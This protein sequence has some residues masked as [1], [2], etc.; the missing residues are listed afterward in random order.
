MLYLTEQGSRLSR[1]G[2]CLVVSRQGEVMA[3]LPAG[4]V[5]QVVVFGNVSITTP[6]LTYLLRNGVD[7]VF[8]SQEGHYFGRLI[9]SSSR[10]GLLRQAQYQA[11]ADADLR[12]RV[13]RSIVCGKLDNYARYLQHLHGGRADLAVLAEMRERAAAAPDISS[14]RGLEGQATAAYFAALRSLVPRHLA[15]PRRTKRP[16]KDPVNSMLSLGYTLLAYVSW[17]AVEQ[18]GLDVYS[19]FLH[20]TVYSRPSLA[21]DLIEEVRTLVDDLVLVAAR[22]GGYG[23]PDFQVR[24]GGVFLG[25]EARKRY[26]RA[27]QEQVLCRPIPHPS[28][29]SPVTVRRALELQARQVAEIVLGRRQ[30]YGP[31]V[32]WRVDGR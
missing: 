13:A 7:C 14:L 2:H 27:F 19:G 23:W 16:P 17:S 8:L 9:S 24:N 26:L 25:D 10:F 32:L 29:Q 31:L 11:L 12:L 3:R 30:T 6:A 21:L 22:Q 4:L 18:V 1:E 15:F 20:A 28:Q 5:E